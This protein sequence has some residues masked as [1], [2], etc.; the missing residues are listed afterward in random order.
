MLGVLN[1][2]NETNANLHMLLQGWRGKKRQLFLSQPATKHENCTDSS[3]FSAILIYWFE[4]RSV[5]FAPIS[6]KHLFE[7]STQKSGTVESQRKRKSSHVFCIV[8]IKFC[9]SST[10]PNGCCLCVRTLNEGDFKYENLIIL[11]RNREIL[12]LKSI[13]FSSLF[14]CIWLY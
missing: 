7:F 3:I 12:R 6:L 5:S 4:H 2:M 9:Q 8:I 11:C 10:Y 14:V 13:F 1:R